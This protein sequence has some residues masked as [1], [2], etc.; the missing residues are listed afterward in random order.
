MSVFM[1]FSA[2]LC[3]LFASSFSSWFTVMNT[4][5]SSWKSIGFITFSSIASRRN[6]VYEFWRGQKLVM[7]PSVMSPSPDT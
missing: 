1:S 5:S 4:R 6:C 2:A 7:P 3:A